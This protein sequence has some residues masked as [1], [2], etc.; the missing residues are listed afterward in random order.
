MTLHLELYDSMANTLLAPVI[1]P[2]AGNSPMAQAADSVTNR[3]A[4]DPSLPPRPSPCKKKPAGSKAGGLQLAGGSRLKPLLQ[5]VAQRP[6]I[7]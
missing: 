1:D 2:E 7:V 5:G 3:M 4:A 6:Y